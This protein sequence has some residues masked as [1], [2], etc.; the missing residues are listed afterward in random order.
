MAASRF[1]SF[2]DLYGYEYHSPELSTQPNSHNR[3]LNVYEKPKILLES[4][5]AATVSVLVGLEQQV[6]TIHKNL[7]CEAS[8]YFRAALSGNFREAKD[9]KITMEEEDVTT[10]KHFQYWLYTRNLLMSQETKNDIDWNVL[11]GLFILGEVRGI[12]H[13]QNAAIDGI[14]AKR[15]TSDWTPL[16]QIRR[17]YDNTPENSPIRRL[18]VDIFCNRAHFDDD[19]WFGDQSFELYNKE[20]LFD[21]SKAFCR[22]KRN[23]STKIT[24]FEAEAVRSDYYVSTSD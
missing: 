10:F 22:L 17:I 21:L 9:Q 19:T 2:D 24:N 6:F 8:S 13:L 12:P 1:P 20:F 7:L 4:F 16:D 5:G 3:D 14:I 15:A 18:F 23:L 11:T